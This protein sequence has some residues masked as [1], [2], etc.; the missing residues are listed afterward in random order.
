LFFLVFL[1]LRCFCGWLHIWYILW[2]TLYALLFV[3][4]QHILAA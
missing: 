1:G 3:I 2:H 4:L